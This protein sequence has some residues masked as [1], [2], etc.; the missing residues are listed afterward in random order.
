MH[1]AAEASVE[2]TASSSLRYVEP[3]D[4]TGRGQG[5]RGPRK[6]I[7]WTRDRCS[8]PVRGAPS[9]GSRQPEHP[10][11]ADRVGRGDRRGV[12]ALRGLRRLRVRDG[13]RLRRR[14]R[15]AGAPASGRADR[16][17]R[18]VARRPLS[19]RA[20]PARDD[21]P[22]LG[23]ARRIRG[24]VR[25]GRRRARVCLRGPARH[26]R[27]PDPAHV[28]S[29]PAVAC[30][31]SRGAHRVKRSHVDG[32]EPGNSSRAAGRRPACLGGRR[33]RRVRRRQ[34]DAPATSSCPAST[35]SCG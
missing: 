29:S 3:Y 33:G 1:L 15:R 8:A 28:A 7:Q 31:N 13:R 27:Y 6:G 12:G 25:S 17:V 30:A 5:C 32:R 9:I 35:S 19:P 10:A 22:R 2:P 34:R 26:R 11:G 16:S 24:G 18:R 4:N 20:L 21:T 14:D 23:G